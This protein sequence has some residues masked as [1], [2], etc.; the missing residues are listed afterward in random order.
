MCRLHR[1]PALAMAKLPSCTT[2]SIYGK[3]EAAFCG[4]GGHMR[5]DLRIW[6]SNFG[7]PG[8]VNDSTI[9]QRSPLITAFAGGDFP[10]A[11]FSYSLG[12]ARRSLPYFLADGIYPRWPIFAKTIPHPTTLK[13]KVYARQ[14]ESF[15]KDIER[16]FLRIFCLDYLFLNGLS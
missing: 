5:T 6:H 15:R 1:L 13:A 2:R 14:Q 10:P 9:V 4:A 7:S 11:G 12:G 3:R 16:C 8:S